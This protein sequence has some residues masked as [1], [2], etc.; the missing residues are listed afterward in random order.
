MILT[1]SDI[2]TPIN[3]QIISQRVKIPHK[4]QW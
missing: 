2:A 1:K 4:K 3:A